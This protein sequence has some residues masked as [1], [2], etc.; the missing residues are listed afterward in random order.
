MVNHPKILAATGFERRHQMLI[1]LL[2]VGAAWCT[3]IIEKDDVV[4]RFVKD[5]GAATRPLEHMSFLGA[6]LLIGLGAYIC[7]KADFRLISWQ[8]TTQSGDEVRHSS[9]S[10]RKDVLLLHYFGEA[11][12]ALGFASLM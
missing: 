11:V 7:T 1:H 2:I 8:T 10:W 4:W 3:Y 12:Y 5:H 6:T 9:S